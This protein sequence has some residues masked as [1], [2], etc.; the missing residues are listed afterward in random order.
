[1]LLGIQIIGVLFGLFM[2]YITFLGM[3]R[4]ELNGREASFWVVAW[5]IFLIFTIMPHSLDFIVK[6]VLDFARTMDFFIVA[7]FIFLIGLTFYNY[8]V[9]KKNRKKLEDLVRKVAIKRAK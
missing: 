5:L 7:G 2:L 1:M 8:M 3:K 4:K 9:V 6:D